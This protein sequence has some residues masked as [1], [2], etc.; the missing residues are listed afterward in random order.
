MAPR[1]SRCL[2][3]ASRRH[4][5]GVRSIQTLGIMSEPLPPDLSEFERYS[6]PAAERKLSNA[7]NLAWDPQM[8]DWDL[9]NSS[10]NVL[11]QVLDL[12]VEQSLSDDE[13]F[14]AMC[15]AVASYDEVLSVGAGNPVIWSTLSEQLK[16]RPR[17]YLSIIWYWAQPAVR[18]EEA[19]PVSAA[20]AEMWEF[21]SEHI[22][23]GKRNDA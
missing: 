20:M 8:Q 18:G 9:T 21:A 17:L 6:L 19:F 3:S 4:A 2:S 1:G 7:L 10:P 15:L 14:S 5:G 22:R 11:P 12:L 13:R 23:T 16:L